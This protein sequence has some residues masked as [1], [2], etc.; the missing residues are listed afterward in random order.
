[1]RRWKANR[2][3]AGVCLLQKNSPVEE[4]RGRTS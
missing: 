1:V 2:P 4:A 3:W